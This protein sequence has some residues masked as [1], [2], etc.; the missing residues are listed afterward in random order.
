MRSRP[1]FPIIFPFFVPFSLLSLSIFL[2]L[3]SYS[4]YIYCSDEDHT[5]VVTVVDDRRMILGRHSVLVKFVGELLRRRC[6]INHGKAL[7]SRSNRRR[8]EMEKTQS[9]LGR[10]VSSFASPIVKLISRAR[11]TRVKY[12][13]DFKTDKERERKREEKQGTFARWTK[14]VGEK[15]TKSMLRLVIL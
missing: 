11:C 4:L 8:G 15:S 10:D 9:E 13:V 6:Q 2:F 3:M 5:Y 14:I 7:L 1:F 12:D